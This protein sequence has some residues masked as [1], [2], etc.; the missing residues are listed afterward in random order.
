MKWIRN[1][2][3]ILL[4]IFGTIL[5]LLHSSVNAQEQLDY[6]VRTEEIGVCGYIFEFM[7]NGN[8]ICATRGVNDKA[9]AEIRILDIQNKSLKKIS[10]VNVYIGKESYHER[11][12]VGLTID[13]NF[14]ENHYVYLYWTYKDEMDGNQYKKVVRFKYDDINNILLQ[15]KVL[16]DKI[17]ANQIHNGGPL[18][19]GPDGMLYI[20]NGDADISL[21]SRKRQLDNPWKRS[22]DVLNGKILRI[23]RD[24][25]IPEDNPFPN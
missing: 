13:P 15:D 2:I 18:E 25:N 11:G 5:S 8:I 3:L 14:N 17:P 6:K 12:L 23:Y 1:I 19:F 24:G 9:E 20:T 16:I 4:I 10:E 21:Q 7:P 22:F